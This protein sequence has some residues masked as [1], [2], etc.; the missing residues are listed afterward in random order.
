M[1]LTLEVNQLKKQF[2]DKSILYDLSFKLHKGEI[3]SIVGPSGSG[4]TTLL[5]ILAGLDAPTDG[6]I[7]MQGKNI[8][9]QKAN[10]RNVSLVFQQ[11]LLFPHMTVKENIRYGAKIA[12][13]D[14][15][16][17]DPL[18]KAIGLELYAD[19]YPSELSGG[20]KQ[21]VALARAM[22][23]EPDVI[24]FDEPFS[25]L[26]PKLRQEMR[27]WVRQ[28]LVERSI[29][30]IFVTHDIDE[31]MIMGDRIALFHEGTF[32]QIDRLS[33]LHEDPANA[34]VARF[35][36]GH[37]VIDSDHYAPLSSCYLSASDAGED[38]RTFEAAVQQITYQN[39][40]AIG[41]IYVDELDEKVSLP[42]KHFTHNDRIKLYIAKS[43]IR[44]FGGSHL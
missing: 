2:H 9:D 8:T 24:L 11:P 16:K 33:T 25:S 36:G 29:T 7:V 42:I 20:Q 18:L 34:F 22:A 12:K 28:F 44:R 30:S 23:T 32:Q 19:H 4:K 21:R 5:R 13:K 43:M 31:A 27:Y 3:L 41:H 26:D 15:K 14:M 39:G 6:S 35:L 38:P 37:L 17:T 1:T 10:K 40:Q